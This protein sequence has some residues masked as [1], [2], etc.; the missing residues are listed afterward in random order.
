M[1]RHPSAIS[2]CVA[3]FVILAAAC[4]GGG[5]EEGTATPPAAVDTETIEE[6]TPQATEETAD[7]NQSFWHAGWK[8][9]LGEVTLRIE[10]SSRI[11]EIGAQFENLGEATATF[12]SRLVLLSGGQSY[13][14][15]T[16]DQEFPRV[17]GELSG[18]GLITF[19]VDDD[20]TLDDATLLVGNPANNQATVPIGPDG[21]DLV[22]LAPRE[23]DV[24]GSAT[25][26]AVTLTVERIEIRADLPDVHSIAEE[27]KKLI[28]VYFSATIGSGIPI[29]EGVL[30]SANVALK[31]PDGTAVAVREDGRS[32]VNELIQGR[33]GTTIQDLSVRFEVPE[34][35][36]GAYAFVVRGRYAAGT[37]QVE[38]EL[39]FMIPAEGEADG[40]PGAAATTADATTPEPA[41]TP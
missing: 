37:D 1:T 30:Q 22:D 33:E 29:G 41:A 39:A 21:D 7:V 11:V 36:E 2:I 27:G 23:I 20:F 35:V 15:P 14:E 17:P 31:L 4:G 25:A 19:R 12:D 40:T 34:P 32:G 16:L 10:G 8:V 5:G 13:D 18:N 38:G 6:A 3:S 24:T 28:I 26:G 9:T